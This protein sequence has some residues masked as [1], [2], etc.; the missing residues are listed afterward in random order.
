MGV[1]ASFLDVRPSTQVTG[2]GSFKSRSLFFSGSQGVH[3]PFLNTDGSGQT[4]LDA[5]AGW[6][7]DMSAPARAEL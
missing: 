3:A 6:V 7:R 1:R 5:L 4:F 2:P